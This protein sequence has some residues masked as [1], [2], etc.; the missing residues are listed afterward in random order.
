MQPK[1]LIGGVVLIALAAAAW[2]TGGDDHAAVVAELTKKASE[3]KPA[4]PLDA[5]SSAFV[6][7]E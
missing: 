4:V 3:N 1:I 7:E 5:T 6:G 2:F